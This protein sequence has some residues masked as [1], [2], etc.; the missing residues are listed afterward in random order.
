M[1]V[2]IDFDFS[3]IGSYI[4]MFRH[5]LLEKPGLANLHICDISGYAGED[6]FC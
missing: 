4:K 2:S 5:L 6:A 3:V 1:S